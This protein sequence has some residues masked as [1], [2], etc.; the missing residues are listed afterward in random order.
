MAF[1]SRLFATKLSRY[2]GQFQLGVEELVGLTGIPRDRLVALEAGEVTPSGDEVLILADVFKC[3]YRFFISSDR[4]APFDETEE[5]FRRHGDALTRSDRWAIQEFLYLCECEAFL[6]A[7]LGRSPAH[8]RF[9]YEARDSYFK[10][11]GIRAAKALRAHLGLAPRHD[12]TD[13]FAILRQLGLRVFRRSLENSE[14]SG[15]FVHHPVAGLCVLVNYAEDVYRQRFTAAHEACHA[16]LDSAEAFVVSFETG[17]SKWRRDDLVEVRANAFAGHFLLPDD[18]VADLSEVTWDTGTLADYANR[19]RVNPA[20]LLFRLRDL[21]MIDD[22]TVATLRGSVKVSKEAKVEP[23][24]G[25]GLTQRQAERK[26]ALLQR[27]LS[28]HYVGL[29]LDALHASHVSIGRAAEMMLCDEGEL[30]EVAALFGRTL[31]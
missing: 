6:L 11:D 12:V 23:E 2:R 25:P 18:L 26:L 24:I 8:P 27:G 17:S 14:V 29:C 21:N 15:L 3:D 9:T 13:V 28:A 19:L 20:T 4:V 30:R 16:F 31:A 1:D 10:R 5:L 22:R 7:E